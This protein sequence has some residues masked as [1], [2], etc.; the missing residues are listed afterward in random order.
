MHAGGGGVLH[1]E[2]DQALPSPEEVV[3]VA[4]HLDGPG[5]GEGSTG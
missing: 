4:V 2:V 5:G 1:H 3:E